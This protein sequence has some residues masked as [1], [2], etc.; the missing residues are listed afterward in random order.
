V[1]AATILGLEAMG[2]STKGFSDPLDALMHASDADATCIVVDL[3]LLGIEGLDLVDAFCALKR[4]SVILFS[5][6]VDLSVAVKAMRTGVDNVLMKPVKPEVLSDAVGESLCA[7]DA[8]P[9]GDAPI[10]TRRER[11]VAEL[12]VSGLNTKEI[13][14]KL[15]IS[16]RT[17][18]FFRASLLRKTHS[19]NLASLVAALIPLGYYP[20]RQ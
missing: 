10:F 6:Y 1:L 13:A 16:P 14:L 5:A 15:S 18:E 7:L 20:S 4:H 11:Q 9:V 17:V 3:K 8:L 12:I 19:K 2:W